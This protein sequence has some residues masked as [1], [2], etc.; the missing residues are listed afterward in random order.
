M[1]CLNQI[2]RCPKERKY[3]WQALLKDMRQKR[4][5]YIDKKLKP[6]AILY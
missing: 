2:K 6:D 1:R 4:A 5:A 3:M